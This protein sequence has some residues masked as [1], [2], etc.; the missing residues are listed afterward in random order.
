MCVLMVG[1]GSHHCSSVCRLPNVS[2]NLVHVETGEAG[3]HVGAGR[4]IRGQR[5]LAAQV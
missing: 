1:D 3:N 4:H 2:M 5:G